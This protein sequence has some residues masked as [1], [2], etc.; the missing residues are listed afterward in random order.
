MRGEV[1]GPQGEILIPCTSVAEVRIVIK[2]S[3]FKDIEVAK[4]AIHTVGHRNAKNGRR[5]YLV[6][7]TVSPC[8]NPPD[9]WLH[10][11]PDRL[12]VN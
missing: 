6:M 12:D 10:P 3:E 5:A 2:D 1:A 11:D 7:T 8:V 9:D 4:V